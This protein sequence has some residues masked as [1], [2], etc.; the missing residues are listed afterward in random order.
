MTD[1]ATAYAESVVSGDVPTGEL[2]RL[3]CER[4]LRNRDNQAKMGL[5]WD[6]DA[7]A[8]FLH[9]AELHHHYKGRWAKERCTCADGDPMKCPRRIVPLP[10]Q[11]FCGGSIVGW[12]RQNDSGEWVRRFDTGTIE[13]ARK[14]GKTHFAAPV[15]HYLAFCEGEP[16]AE[17]YVAAA[18]GHQAR[19][20][21]NILKAIIRAS[22]HLRT[23]LGGWNQ[24]LANIHEDDSM[25]YVQPVSSESENLD[26]LS[27]HVI[28]L[29][30][31]HAHKDSS[32]RDVLRTGM[33]GRD[34]PFTL[35]I[36][37]AGEEREDSVMKSERDYGEQILRG[38]VED[39]TVFAFIAE[40]DPK[41]DW[42]DLENYYKSNP[43]LGYTVRIEDLARDLEE[44]KAKPLIRD[45]FKIKRANMWLS[46][47]SGMF[48]AEAWRACD[49]ELDM[50]ALRNREC[51]AGIDL[52]ESIDMSA[53]ALV[54]PP[55]DD[56]LWRVLVHYWLPSA[57]LEQRAV[58]DKPLKRWTSAGL[59][60]VAGENRIDFNFI[61][62]RIEELSTRYRIAEIGFDRWRAT[63]LISDLEV[64][65]HPVVGVPYGPNTLGATTDDLVA[66]VKDRKL[67]YGQNPVLRWN[68]RHCIARTDEGGNSI[69]SKKR[70]RGNIDGISATILGMSRARAAAG[71]APRE[72][73]GEVHF[74]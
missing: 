55:K 67:C 6:V 45:S 74:A 30:E 54:F 20:V 25:S 69:P 48:D 39:E 9:F 11:A 62:R 18:A 43:S 46:V 17:G 52:A 58:R 73:T 56:D 7:V 68:A 35:Q 31:L 63:Q 29:D 3:A 24:K 19:Y 65:G 12:K 28:L 70:S 72:L 60:E 14:Q 8:D 16:A 59:I 2:V 5:L 61:R 37:T 47:F 71:A 13:M 49:T 34:Q 27:P 53:L 36:S 44:A 66:I 23:M 51:W 21:H 26:A 41:D 57:T 40:M 32:V 4:H 33:G 10:W 1:P 38:D 50:E 42:T 15:V 22:P 64:A